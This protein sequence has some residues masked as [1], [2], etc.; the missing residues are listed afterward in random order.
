M[1]VGLYAHFPHQQ[2][3]L[4]GIE[5]LAEAFLNDIPAAGLLSLAAL[6]IPSRSP[7]SV[8]FN[9]SPRLALVQRLGTAATI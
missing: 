9:L 7:L 6:S 5:F 2:L 8:I 4:A 3:A 1:V